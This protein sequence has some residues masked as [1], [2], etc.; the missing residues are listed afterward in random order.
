MSGKIGVMSDSHDQVH[1]LAAVMDFYRAQGIEALIHCGDWI[2]PFTLSYYAGLDVPLYGV[3]GNN[4]GDKFLHQRVAQRLGLNLTMEDELLTLTL[5]ERKIAVYH[6]TSAGIVSALA[7]C[8]DYDLVCYG[9]NHVAHIEHIGPTLTFNPGTLMD[10]T[11]P[12]VRGASIGLY[13][14]RAH[15]AVL[16]WLTTP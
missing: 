15:T 7:K 4:D 13:D 8:G 12:S 10:V 9:H 6:G 11:N 1:H 16:H 14:A 2:S 3:Y 5:Y